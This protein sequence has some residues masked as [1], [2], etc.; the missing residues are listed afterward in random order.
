MSKKYN[1]PHLIHTF[2]IVDIVTVAIAAK[3]R[4]VNDALRIV[5][6]IIDISHENRNTF[7]TEYGVL[8][9]SY[10][11][12]E[13]NQVSAELA[14]PL[15]RKLPDISLLSTQLTI[16]KSA[17]LRSLT[18][19]LPVKCKCFTNW[20]TRRCHFK[21][22][23]VLCTQYCYSEHPASV[24][25]PDSIVKQTEVFLVSRTLVSRRKEAKNNSLSKQKRQTQ[26]PTS[27]PAKKRALVDQSLLP[28]IFATSR[29]LRSSILTS[30]ATR[31]K[32]ISL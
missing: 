8:S 12:F 18:L 6:R 21:K 23:K 4:A 29:S 14:G 27:K 9:N 28:P 16:H 7:Q 15:Q 10:S 22:Q 20:D 32:S 11:T 1:T 25:L 31:S 24:H 2:K 26:T 5:A 17:A 19:T 3:D 13:L 30:L